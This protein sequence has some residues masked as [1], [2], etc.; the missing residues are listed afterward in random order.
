MPRTVTLTLTRAQAQALEY[1]AGN[2][3]EHEDAVEAVFSSGSKRKC[4]KRAYEKLNAAIG[5]AS[6]NKQ[7]Q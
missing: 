5:A 4:A 7:E 6:R 1:A 2:I 3:M